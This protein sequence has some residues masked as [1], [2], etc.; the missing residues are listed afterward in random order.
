MKLQCCQVL[1]VTLK[2]YGVIAKDLFMQKKDLKKHTIQNIQTEKKIKMKKTKLMAM[3]MHMPILI[4]R[5]LWSSGLN[6]SV[7][8]YQIHF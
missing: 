5:P 8:N 3:A 6:L 2:D 7:S 4:A 1:M